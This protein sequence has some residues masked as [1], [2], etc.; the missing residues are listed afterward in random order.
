MAQDLYSE[1]G[2]DRS[3]SADDVRKAFRKLAKT[4]HPDQN[5]NDKAAE[6]RFKR[7]SA[8]FDILG[9]VEKRAKYD[10]GEI[11]GDGRE[12]HRG[13]PGGNGGGFPGHGGG[14]EGVDVDEIFGGMFSGR[15]RGGRGFAM[16][17]SDVQARLDVDLEETI[18]GAT[19]RISFQDGR[20]LDV[21]IPKGAVNGQTLRLRGQGYPGR[22]GGP[23]GDA[24]IELAIRPHPVF[25]IEGADLHMDL[26][27]S[28]PDAV[29]GAK[30]DAP[31]PDGTVALTVP[32]H[33]NSGAVLRLRGRGGYDG[34][35]AKR[36]DLFA[37]LVVTLP[38]RIDPE[39]EQI[40][41][42]WR[43]D[44]PYAPGRR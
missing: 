21:T 28:V 6:E 23:T 27:V 19:R 9:D 29:L 20:T 38:E 33:S 41:E 12:V 13:F 34:G 11:D 2:V 5:P 36:G 30:V 43:K 35:G 8:A 26:P 3:A 15:A 4:L 24:L 31:T 18:K 32:R 17:G 16:R 7:L 25:R 10:R 44:H 40:A 1:L 14:F 37:R 39:L 42:T 22:G